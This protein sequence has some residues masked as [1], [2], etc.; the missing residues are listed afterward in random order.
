MHKYLLPTKWPAWCLEHSG[1]WVTGSRYCSP[2]HITSQACPLATSTHC[3]LSGILVHHFPH[4]SPTR[5]FL[6]I[7]I[8]PDFSSSIKL[9]DSAHTD[10]ALVYLI[11]PALRVSTLQ[12]AGMLPGVWPLKPHDPQHRFESKVG[13]GGGWDGGFCYLVLVIYN[14]WIKCP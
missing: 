9:S 11:P 13:V 8:L 1:R 6:L 2:V 12:R 5:P 4:F 7:W 14:T 3:H 10:L